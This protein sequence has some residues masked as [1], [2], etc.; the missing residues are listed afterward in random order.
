M[1]KEAIL[2]QIDNLISKRN[3]LLTLVIVLAGGSIGLTFNFH[4]KWRIILFFLG[5]ISF[6]FFLI[7]MLNIDDRIN[8]LIK[9]LKE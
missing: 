9:D 3:N 4:D 5:I 1:A 6:V 8:S 7:N 2:K